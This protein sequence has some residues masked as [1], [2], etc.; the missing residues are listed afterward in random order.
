MRKCTKNNP[1]SPERDTAE[2]GIGWEHEGAHEVPDSQRSDWP[3]GDLVDMKCDDCGITWT[4]EL[5]Q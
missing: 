2:P 5:P 3:S 4:T 1:Y